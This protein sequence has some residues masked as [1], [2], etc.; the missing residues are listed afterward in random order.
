MTGPQ[1]H[2]IM[3]DTDQPASL[4]ATKVRAELLAT[5]A[6]L[7]SDSPPSRALLA[8]LRAAWPV[9]VFIDRGMGD[10]LELATVIDVE[11]GTHRPADAPAWYDRR[12]AA[13]ARD[14]TVYANRSSLGAV[15]AAMGGRAHFRWIA[16]LD[17]T[18]HVPP[19]P[20]GVAPAAIQ[21]LGAA[22]LGFHA[23]MSIVFEPW[24][25]PTPAAAPSDTLWIGHA[26]TNLHQAS[27]LL[28]AHQ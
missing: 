2:R 27:A 3:Y 10:P 8:E 9:I 16:T 6:D 24:W 21:I 22:A 19:F 28:Q 7:F 26:L 14:L 12:H 20:A 18:A 13:G 23:D 15:D 4:T 5:Y 11:R 1:L 25:N 17:G